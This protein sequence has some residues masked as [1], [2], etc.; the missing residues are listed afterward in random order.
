MF[1]ELIIII[2]PT[3]AGKSDRA[4]DLAPRVGGEIISADSRHVYCRMDIGTNKPSLAD[5]SIV[6]HHLIDLREPH[7]PFSLGEYVRLA[8]AAMEDVRRR[9]KV[10]LL[11]GGTGQYVRALLEGWRVPEV[12]LSGDHGAIARWRAQQ[13]G[14]AQG[15][16]ES[17]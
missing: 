9:G 10:P 7:E 17:G 8:R 12:L 16:G 3:A 6:P 2:G 4:M 14:R 13:V 11:V 15:E 1:P 5:R